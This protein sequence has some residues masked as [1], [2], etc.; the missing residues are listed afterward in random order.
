MPL[1]LLYV[2]SYAPYSNAYGQEA[3]DAILIGAS[4]EQVV[5]VLFI[6]D[7][8]FQIK[9]SQSTENN[10]IKPF[11]KTYMALGDFGV[12]NVF[13]HDLSLLARNV[14]QRDLI[15]DT[16]LLTSAQVAGVLSKYD[17]VYTFWVHYS[18][19]ISHGTVM[20]GYLRRYYLP[21]A[22]T[23]LCCW[24]TLYLRCNRQPLWVRLWRNV[25]PWRWWWWR[26]PK[27]VPCGELAINTTRS[28]WSPTPN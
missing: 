17:R 5:S 4:F 14:S 24:K 15:I 21:L 2:V 12:D 28:H 7:G 16:Q 26:K 23:P 11:T 27:I 18:Q 8:V 20:L 22:V 3:L 9:S 19:S 1:K 6:N 10:R 13:V 25:R